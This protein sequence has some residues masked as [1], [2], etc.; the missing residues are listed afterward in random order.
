[1]SR[2]A[3]SR[4]HPYVT[5][6]PKAS[7]ITTQRNTMLSVA[8]LLH[9]EATRIEASGVGQ[10]DT[11]FPSHTTDPIRFDDADLATLKN[12]FFVRGK[13]PAAK[14]ETGEQRPSV[15]ASLQRRGLVLDL[16]SQDGRSR[17]SP[18][19]S[20]PKR[21]AIRTAPLEHE[22]TFLFTSWPCPR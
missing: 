4:G 22:Q 9:L 19:P 5:R 17:P 6:Y 16:S 1:A 13:I 2:P 20:V 10:T 18:R 3:H 14:I 8:A 21:L 12:W 11:A 15:F 7:A